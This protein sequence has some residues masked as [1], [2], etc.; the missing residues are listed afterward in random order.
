LLY[1]QF[2]LGASPFILSGAEDRSTLYTTSYVWP[3]NCGDYV[4]LGGK[5]ELKHNL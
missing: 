4:F 5:G 2:H 1:C 3:V